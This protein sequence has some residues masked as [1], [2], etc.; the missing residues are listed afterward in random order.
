MRITDCG[1][2]N[3]SGLLGAEFSFLPAKVVSSTTPASVGVG[4][5]AGSA[6]A[7]DLEK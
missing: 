2:S 3:G 5:V 1:A 7:A 4:R 6:G